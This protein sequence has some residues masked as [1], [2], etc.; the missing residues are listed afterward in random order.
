MFIGEYNHSLD[1]KGRIAI[2]SKFR[3]LLKGG[4]MVTRG[5]DNCLFLYPKKEWQ[6]QAEKYKSLPVISNP[7]ARELAHNFFGGSSEIDFDG[8]GR[9]L[10]P[11]NLR[12][13]AKMKKKVVIVGMFDKLEIWD[14][15]RWQEY[16]NKAE[17]N[18][19]LNAES[20]ADLG[21]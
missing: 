6:V 19:N 13:F 12:Q 11:D 20:L 16:R 18:N 21:I 17:Q 7:Q 15:E 2:P 3:G 4:A 8:Q 5:L 9:T 1:D 14:E 10:L